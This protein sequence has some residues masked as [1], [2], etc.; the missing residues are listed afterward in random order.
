MPNHASQ[1]IQ[2]FEWIS[3]SKLTPQEED[4]KVR[5]VVVDEPFNQL[6]TSIKTTGLVSPFLVIPAKSPK[7]IYVVLGGNRRLMATQEA[8]RDNAKNPDPEIPCMVGPQG[9]SALDQIALAAIDNLHRKN[10]E[11]SEVYDIVKTLRKMGVT[12]QTKQAKLLGLSESYLSQIITAFRGGSTG[13]S[14]REEYKAKAKH[15]RTTER[16]ETFPCPKC[17]SK[18]D[19]KWDDEESTFVYSEHTPGG[20]KK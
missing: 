6:V 12:T 5:P 16:R 20:P 8:F 9:V 18:I 4:L 19:R 11:P 15:T 14:L 13:R 2:S 10:F 1:V 7:G 17:G 3:L